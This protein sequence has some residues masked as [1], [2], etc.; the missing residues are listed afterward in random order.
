LPRAKQTDLA[1]A[2]IRALAHAPPADI[3]PRLESLFGQLD[4]I[5]DAY[6]TNTHFALS[7]L[8]VVESAVFALLA[9]LHAP[10]DVLRARLEEEEFIIR[11]RIHQS[12][13][14]ALARSG[15]ATA[16]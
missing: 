2:W 14:A 16:P 5:C 11:R 15:P 6:S 10:D 12:V 7:E 9:H 4:G 13:Q 3:A 8:S 1:V